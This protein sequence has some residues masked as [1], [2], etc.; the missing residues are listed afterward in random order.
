VHIENCTAILCHAS[1]R[2][3]ISPDAA[4]APPP[5]RR[6]FSADTDLICAISP[7]SAGPGEKLSPAGA[8]GAR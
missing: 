1:A 8:A 4:D 6:P 3:E 5:F 7:G 2:D